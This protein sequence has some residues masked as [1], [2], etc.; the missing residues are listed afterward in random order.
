MIKLKIS[1]I[2]FSNVQ[3]TR[4]MIVGKQI[5]CK[6]SDVFFSNST[7]EIKQINEFQQLYS[8]VYNIKPNVTLQNLFVSYC[9][10]AY[11]FRL[12]TLS[13]FELCMQAKISV[14]HRRHDFGKFR[15]YIG[16]NNVT[17]DICKITSGKA[18][19]M[20]MNLFIDEFKKY[21]NVLQECPMKVCQLFFGS[22]FQGF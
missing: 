4:Y 1:Q 7:C 20:V 6:R 10:I 18:N 17:L 2:Y 19:Y 15:Q 21:G 13:Y 14:Q 22:L 16:L 9:K 5:I 12:Q 11:D 3:E 8:V